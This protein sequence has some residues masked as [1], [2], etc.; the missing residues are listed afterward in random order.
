MNTPAHLLLG[1]AVF[2]RGSRRITGFALLGAFAPDA[3][4]YIMGGVSLFLMN[5]PPEVVF[6]ELYFSPAWQTVFA[7]DNSIFLWIAG[8]AIALWA[9]SPSGFAFAGA[10][11]L[12]LCLDFP[13]HAGDGRAHFWPVSD[14]VFHSPFSY[15]DSAHHANWVAPA[16]VALCFAAFLVLWRRTPT[17]WG[18]G[19]L[20]LLLAA[21]IWVARQWLTLF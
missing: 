20:T 12:H 10:G 1:A 17:L 8:L 6:G 2:G 11:L 15:W 5:I 4:L 9:A 18:R 21:E 7:I 19:G 3:S 16:S 13:L 14:W